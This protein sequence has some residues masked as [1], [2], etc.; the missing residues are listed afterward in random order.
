MQKLTTKLPDN[1]GVYI[2]RG[3]KRVILYI[4]KATSLHTRVASYFRRDLISTR[5]PIIAG[6]IEAAKNVDFIET[7][8]VLEALILEAQLIKK[9]QPP[10]NTKEKDNKSFNYVV[11]TKEDFPRVTTMRGREMDELANSRLGLGLKSEVKY[12]FGPFPQGGVLREALN[13][14]RK[15]FPFRDK[16]KVGQGKPCFNAQIGLCPGV[17]AGLVSKTEYAK[18]I[19]RT[20]LFFEGK[21]K[22]LVSG[23]LREMK[24]SA[25]NLKFEEAGQIKR[26]IFALN[27]IQDVALLK[28]S[29]RMVLGEAGF[30]IEAYDVAHISGTNT[31]GVM[32][33][34]E[35]S[36][37]KKSDYRKFKIKTS[38]NDDNAS[39]REI[40]E[41]RFNH[42][43]WPMPKLIVVDGGTAQVNT[44][45][46]ALKEWGLA[47]PVVGVVKDERHKPKSILGDKILAQS[48]ERSILLANSE[49]HRFAIGF[50][51]QLRGKI[52]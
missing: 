40:L 20:K 47:I 6:M 42:A 41:R 50:H 49:A 36:E 30:R 9:H 38:T 37:P 23:L 45:K 2:F 34:L 44:A 52:R 11:I 13:I 19:R 46:K 48:H 24:V 51:R 16:C 43:E 29:P 1:P 15:I 39:L 22:T 4:G 31:V 25:N 14:V 32:T 7:D 26:T 5:G 3:P 28:A 33:V 8:S 21:K 10:Y 18:T 17:C 27:H 12:L 35:D